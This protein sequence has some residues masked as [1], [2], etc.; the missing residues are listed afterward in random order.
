MHH[1]GVIF[2]FQN[3]PGGTENCFACVDSVWRRNVLNDTVFSSGSPLKHDLFLSIAGN[4]FDLQLDC[5]SIHDSRKLYFRCAGN[6]F[7]NDAPIS[8]IP[9][10]SYPHTIA[11]RCDV[12]QIYEPFGLKSVKPSLI[13][14]LPVLPKTHGTFT[15]RPIQSGRVL[16]AYQ[17]RYRL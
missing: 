5:S 16:C 10:I 3:I 7:I 13:I 4:C 17:V 6:R 11:V 1:S 14:T 12:A 2:S 8:V 15:K 9:A